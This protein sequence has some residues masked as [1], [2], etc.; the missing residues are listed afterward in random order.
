MTISLIL[1]IS[2]PATTVYVILATLVA[3]SL[4]HLGVTPLAAHMFVFYFGI[5][6]TITPP[7]A[8]TAYAA[9]AIGGGSAIRVS[10][11][12]FLLGFSSYA[13]P[14]VL[15]YAPEIMLTADIP[16]ALLRFAI[17]IAA[18]FAIS[19]FFVGFIRVKLTVPCRVL[20]GITGL[21]LITP[22]LESDLAGFLLLA[23]V[24]VMH[25]FRKI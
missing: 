3:P 23:L 1:G 5:I 25:R 19:L 4:A 22:N 11:K 15:V 20:A 16:S 2:M 6:S 7:V 18:V 9:S 12:A 14:F 8:L 10:V 13:I 21:F 17:C 24:L